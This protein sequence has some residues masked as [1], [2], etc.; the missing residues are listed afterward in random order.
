MPKGKFTKE[1][2]KLIEEY[3]RKPTKGVQWLFYVNAFIVAA[4]PIW[5]AWRILQMDLVTYSVLF[6]LMTLVSTYVIAFSY[7]KVKENLWHK[8]SRARRPVITREMD[9]TDKKLPKPQK[10]EKIDWK[11]NEVSDREATAF[12]IF[13]NNALYMLVFLA[14]AFYILH[15]FHV[16]F[17][18]TVSTAMAS[19]VLALLSTGP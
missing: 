4:I 15:S 7:G 9:V 8:I 5:L 14:F 3:S 16:A 13:Y 17:N 10:D 11:T 19:F 12:S 18:Y 1:E 2:E 6:V